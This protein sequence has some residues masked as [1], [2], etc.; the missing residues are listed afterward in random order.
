MLKSKMFKCLLLSCENYGKLRRCQRSMGNETSSLKVCLSSDCCKIPLTRYLK[1][2]T[3]TTWNFGGWEVQDQIVRRSD[4][5]WELTSWFTEGHLVVGPHMTEEALSSSSLIR[6]HFHHGAPPSYPH[7]N[8][9][10]SQRP[11]LQI[12]SH[13]GLVVNIQ[14]WGAG[15]KHSV[16]SKI[17]DK[18]W[19]SNYNA[20]F[21]ALGCF[22]Y[23]SS[24]SHIVLFKEI[25]NHGF[26]TPCPYSFDNFDPTP[27][28]RLWPVPEVYSQGH[29]V[30]LDIAIQSAHNIVLFRRCWG[31]TQVLSFDGFDPERMPGHNFSSPQVIEGAS[32]FDNGVNATHGGRLDYRQQRPI[33]LDWNLPWS[34]PSL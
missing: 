26:E 31:K 33:R 11:H 20:D 18:C 17:L 1:Q 19:Q 5:W 14:I 25:Q 34:D 4:V 22:W 13:W 3:F 29:S 23:F 21:K 10:T 16:H 6:H 9:N 27:E 12:P 32:F 7:P 15:N 8:L 24:I 2:Q 28:S 30:T